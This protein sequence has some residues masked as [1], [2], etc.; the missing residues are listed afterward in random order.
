MQFSILDAGRRPRSGARAAF[1]VRD[2]W[3]DWFQYVTQFKLYVADVQG[4][5]HHVGDVKIGERG[6]GQTVSPDVPSSFEALDDRFF[7]LGQDDTYYENLNRL[8]ADLRSEVLLAL[9]DVAA[10]LRLLEQV[11]DEPVMHQSLMRFVR[12]STIVTQ[13]HRIATGGVRLTR[14]HFAYGV[15]TL[16]APADG[17]EATELELEFEVEP[18]S[19][20]PTN[21]HVLI[22]RNGV[23][24]TTLLQR[25]SKRLLI[26]DPEGVQYG[27]LRFESDDARARVFANIVSVSFSAFDEFKPVSS[28]LDEEKGESGLSYAYVGLHD[29]MR[30]SPKLPSELG[31]EFVRSVGT[32]RVGARADRW[33][34][35]L[36]TLETDPLFQ[37]AQVAELVDEL[38]EDEWSVEASRLFGNLSSGHKIVLL[39]VTRLVES[40]EERTLVLI[41]EPE[42]H[43]HPPLLAAFVRALS[44]LLTERN[45]VAI[46]ATH[47]PV[48]LQEV[49]RS[50]VWK[51][52][53]A[54]GSL[55]AERP[56]LET[57]GENVGILTRD[58][59]GLE[60]TRSGF[61]RMLEEAV[62]DLRDYDA[63]TARFGEQLGMEARALVRAMLGD[64]AGDEAYQAA[65][66]GLS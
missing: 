27:S 44:D 19:A 7:S 22:G 39:T 29:A 18:E 62:R 51:L 4:E 59:F 9:R 38:S 15:A 34:K 40:V 26:S 25:L 52:R 10:D 41:D 21:I 33:R 14:Y 45:G 35:A 56:A 61:H 11:R 31:Q 60:V 42:A 63:V 13:F 47:S 37:A 46:V 48:V 54:G 6:M 12:W 43:L 65:D 36:R 3:N 5:I 53:R 32:C 23:G 24:K 58:V 17:L 66:G 28:G 30:S 1:L 55:R 64:P 16:G 50:C 57:F 8:G 2:N 20:P 49:P